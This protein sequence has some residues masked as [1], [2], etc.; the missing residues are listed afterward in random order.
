MGFLHFRRKT[1]PLTITVDA[2]L[3]NSDFDSGELEAVPFTRAEQLAAE[4]S[5]AKTRAEKGRD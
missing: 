1:C 3:T 4:L 2:I 5:E